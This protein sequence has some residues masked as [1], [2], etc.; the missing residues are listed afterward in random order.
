MSHSD[1]NLVRADG[2]PCGTVRYTARLT[3]TNEMDI[4]G[5]PDSD[6]FPATDPQVRT[7]ADCAARFPLMAWG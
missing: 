4:D 6:A 7:R 1:T 5:K 3:M 2:C